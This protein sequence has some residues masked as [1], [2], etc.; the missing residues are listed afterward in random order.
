[1]SAGIF[2]RSRAK[3]MR[4]VWLIAALVA[5][6]LGSACGQQTK[7][8]KPAAKKTAPSK[9][10]P[11]AQK[12]AAPKPKSVKVYVARHGVTKPRLLPMGRALTVFKKCNARWDGETELS[13]LVDT[14]GRP[15]NIMFLRPAGSP[16]DRFAIFIAK[17]DHFQPG[18]LNGKPVVVAETLRIKL[19]TC[20]VGLKD[21]AGKVTAERVLRSQ[22]HQKLKS[23][24]NPP[25]EAI[26]TP[27]D[28][29]HKEITH[30]VTRPDFFGGNVTAPVLL[31]S[32]NAKYT[33]SHKTASI[34]GVCQIS[35]IV[36]EHGLPR[37]EH[38]LK[39]LDPGLDHSALLAVALYRFF[40][41]IKDNLEPVPAAIVVDVRFAP[42]RSGDAYYQ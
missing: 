22:P 26:L 39:S 29:D 12:A 32:T 42:P 38:V 34:K 25:L 3:R 7:A 11:A 2:P 20:V 15:R 36:D 14:Q 28:T 31:Y 24:K 37:D 9:S 40:P 23:P 17:L 21:N 13:L 19:Q 10:L 4:R 33:P 6:G 5:L 1:M 8:P 18:T 27:L 30:K 16:V 41:A 35:L